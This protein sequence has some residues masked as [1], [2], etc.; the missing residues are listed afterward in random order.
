MFCFD[1]R[2]VVSLTIVPRAAACR[3]PDPWKVEKT[4]HGY[5]IGLGVG[6]VLFLEKPDVLS[7]ASP[8]IFI[9]F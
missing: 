5:A 3:L 8:L 2:G 9:D 1:V 6:R 4:E 7:P